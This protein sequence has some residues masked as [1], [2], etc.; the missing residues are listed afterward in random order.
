MTVISG[1]IIAIGILIALFMLYLLKSSND[2]TN[3]S[4]RLM[5]LRVILQFCAILIMV[6]LVYLFGR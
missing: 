3:R 1:A 2:K 4:Q 6:G 5:R